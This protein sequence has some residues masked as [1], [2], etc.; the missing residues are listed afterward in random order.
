LVAA[1]W[2]VDLVPARFHLSE[3]TREDEDHQS[4]GAMQ[5]AYAAIRASGPISARHVLRRLEAAAEHD[6]IWPGALFV[7]LDDIVTRGGR[8]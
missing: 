1:A 7:L 2:L 6:V 8:F 5:T 3:R 4:A